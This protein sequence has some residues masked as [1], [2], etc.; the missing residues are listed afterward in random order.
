MDL[1]R[2]VREQIEWDGLGG[3]P[4]WQE[5]HMRTVL[6]RSAVLE[7]ALKA[8]AA[9]RNAGHRAIDGGPERHEQALV[10]SAGPAV[11]RNARELINLVGEKR[12]GEL[13]YRDM[14]RL[15]EWLCPELADRPS[16]LAIEHQARRNAEIQADFEQ[17]QEM[18]TAEEVHALRGS[19]AKNR[20]ALAAF[21]RAKRRI[22]GIRS[23]RRWLFPRFQF[24]E[25]QGRPKAVIAETLAALGD[26]VGPWQTAIWFTSGNGL[27][28]GR[29]P[30][31]LVDRN[32]S[33]VVDAARAVSEPT[34]Y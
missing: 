10:V 11:L 24:D 33:A 32:P 6:V 12:L 25:Q 26:A 18:L 31:E 22:F 23:R 3:D 7:G 5:A 27:L 9:G 13:E 30:V 16:L 34:I 8:R 19:S 4:E 2:D 17:T 15:M 29:K 1:L 21:W 14:K 28:D 20:R